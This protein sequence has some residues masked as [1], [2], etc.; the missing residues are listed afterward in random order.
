[1]FVDF[2]LLTKAQKAVIVGIVAFT[3][4]PLLYSLGL[5][6]ALNLFYLNFTKSAPLG[7]YIAAQDQRLYTG[8]YVIMNV[9][10]EMKPYLY[11]RGWAMERETRL[12]KQIAGLSLDSYK[13]EN[14]H[15]TINRQRAVIQK[16]DHENLPLPKPENGN[17][18][19]PT[20]KFMPISLDRDNSFD[21]RY[22]GPVEESLIVKKVIPFLVLPLCFEKYI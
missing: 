16:T 22:T 11:G 6:P 12:L 18:I 19:I 17:Y 4:F 10:E 14:N 13:I 1:M 9:P 8:D 2:R 15:I 7:V 21:A 20:G 3:C 5:L